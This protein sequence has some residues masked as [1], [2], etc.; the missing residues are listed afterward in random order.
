MAAP[1]ADS[2]NAFTSIL[3]G[4]LYTSYGSPFRW[5]SSRSPAARAA[6]AR[7][8]RRS[9]SPSRSPPMAPASGWSTPTCTARTPHM[10]GLHRTQ[11]A[12]HVTVFAR[13]GTAAARLEA[14]RRHGLQLASAAFLIG[15]S[16]GLG[17]GAPIAPAA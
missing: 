2:P 10:M 16:Q 15:K 6:S 5:T 11:D 4:G 3:R 8:R 14:V 7:R 12:A 1:R 9:T 13:E 17:V